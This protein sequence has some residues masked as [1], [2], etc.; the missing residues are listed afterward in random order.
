MPNVTKT[1]W[2]LIRDL[3]TRCQTLRRQLLDLEN[4]M[5]SL[6][7]CETC[8]QQPSN[9]RTMFGSTHYTCPHLFAE[10]PRRIG[11]NPTPQHTL[12]P[13]GVSPWAAWIEVAS[14]PR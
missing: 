9:A 4:E 6:I 7:V 10:L 5:L 2:A 3:N 1:N 13:T 8:N 12:P 14:T 11:A